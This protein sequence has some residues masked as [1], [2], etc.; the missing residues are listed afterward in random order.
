MPRSC[1]FTGTSAAGG[2]RPVLQHGFLAVTW[3]DF[4][5]LPCP[6]PPAADREKN[7]AVAISANPA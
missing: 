5:F 3:W 7:G 2:I 4:E 6:P 1:P